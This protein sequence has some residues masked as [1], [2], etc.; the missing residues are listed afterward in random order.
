MGRFVPSG[1]KQVSETDTRLRV[2]FSVS[3]E[4]LRPVAVKDANYCKIHTAR[5]SAKAMVI[6]S[7]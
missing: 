2:R 5:L 7:G 3:G 6:Q 4:V 1:A